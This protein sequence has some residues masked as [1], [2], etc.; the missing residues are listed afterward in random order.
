MD[1]IT[2]TMYTGYFLLILGTVGAVI[3]PM[4]KDPFKR[5]LNIEVP[6]IGV[7]LVFLAY[8][9]TL[10]LMTFLGV[11]AILTLILVRAILKNVELEE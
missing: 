5:L 11:N 7:C 1:L 9:Q 10:A 3:G 4:T 6:S 2:L 8:N